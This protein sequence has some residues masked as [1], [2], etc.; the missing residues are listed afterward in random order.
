M[1]HIS[2]LSLFALKLALT[3]LPLWLIA[4]HLDLESALALMVRIEWHYAAGAALA[5]VAQILLVGLRLATISRMMGATIRL[6]TT[7]PITWIGTFFSQALISFISG[8]VARVWLLARNGLALRQ[9]TNTVLLDRAFG[10][11]ALVLLI[12]GGI[13][14]LLAALPSPEMQWGAAVTTA[15]FAGG[16]AVFLLLGWLAARRP[17]QRLPLLHAARFTWIADF[18]SAARYVF[19]APAQA[20]IALGQGL[21][22]HGLSVLAVFWLFRGI[23]ATSLSLA[24]CFVLV[25][26]IILLAM[27]PISVAGWGVREGAM[28]MGFSTLAI[29]SEISLAVSIAFGF[30]LLLTS[31]PGAALW[32]LARD[33]KSLS[34]PPT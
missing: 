19:I 7:V 10:V 34:E 9:A 15:G 29:A 2:T 31:L 3:A 18:A 14:P 25:P 26:F 23:G 22:V 24:A 32:L 8:D 5:A 17:D 13:L 28:I 20:L 6:T 1:R 27:L 30:I 4:S 21:V 33:R 11:I 12:L 16:I